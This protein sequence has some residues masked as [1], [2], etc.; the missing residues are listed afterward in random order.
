LDNAVHWVVDDTWWDERDPLASIGEILRDAEEAEA[1]RRVVAEVVGVSSRQSS[2]D[3]DW[4]GDPRWPEVRESAA[5]AAAL[6][7]RPSGR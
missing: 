7:R 4:F 3:A 5:E 2:A 1:V 6:L